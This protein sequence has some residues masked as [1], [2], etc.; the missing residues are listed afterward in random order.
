MLEYLKFLKY[1][2][3]MYQGLEYYLS[4]W[5]AD[6]NGTKQAK[7]YQN[8]VTS[9][10]AQDYSAILASLIASEHIFSVSGDIVTNKRNRLLPST[11]RYLLCLQD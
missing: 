11:L 8:L 7:Q 2:A 9:Q 5:Q 1:L 4:P 6:A 3:S 10:I